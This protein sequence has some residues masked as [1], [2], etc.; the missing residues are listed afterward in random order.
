M[1]GHPFPLPP[2]VLYTEG[3]SEAWGGGSWGKPIVPAI[4]SPLPEIYGCLFSEP[5][6]YIPHK[7]L[8]PGGPRAF[9]VGSPILSAIL[10]SDFFAREMQ[11]Q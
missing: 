4:N 5:H 7:F 9:E 6:N 10:T 3:T 2:P 11:S 1:R 8:W